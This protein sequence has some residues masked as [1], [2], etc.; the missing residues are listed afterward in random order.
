MSISSEIAGKKVQESPRSLV[1]L[2]KS[3]KK[4]FGFL[5][6]E[7]CKIILKGSEIV[8]GSQSDVFVYLISEFGER[9]ILQSVDIGAVL[10]QSSHLHSH[11][12]FIAEVII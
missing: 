6:L 10:S 11:I 2:L 8:A 9:A 12:Q 4:T 1:F 5:L 7:Y 3:Y